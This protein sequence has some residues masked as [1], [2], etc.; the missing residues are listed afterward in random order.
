MHLIFCSKFNHK[1]FMLVAFKLTTSVA[2]DGVW[3]SSS[4]VG[5]ATSVVQAALNTIAEWSTVVYASERQQVLLHL[6]LDGPQAG[7]SSVFPFAF[8]HSSPLFIYYS[9]S[10]SCFD[11]TLSFSNHISYLRFAAIPRLLAL[12]SISSL[13]WGPSAES[14]SPLLLFH[15]L[16]LSLLLFCLVSLC[17]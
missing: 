10:W 12:K 13:S 14:L 4:S 1:V 15:S 17:L 6:V 11:R 16:S 3:S 5:V 9:F 2:E 7:S 8:W